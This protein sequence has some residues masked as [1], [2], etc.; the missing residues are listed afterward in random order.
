MR[1]VGYYFTGTG[2]TKRVLEKL[3]AEWEKRG[4]EMELVRIL[5]NT[6][7]ALDGYDRIIVGYPVHGFNAP[8]PIYKFLKAFPKCKKG[9]GKEVFLL[10]TSGEPLSL[11][12]ASGIVPARIL[13]RRGHSVVGEF[14][15]VMPYNIIFRHPDGMAAR[16]DRAS[17]L[18]I[19]KDC[20]DLEAGKGWRARVNPFKRAFTFLVRIEHPA[21]PVF[22]V[23]FHTKKKLCVGCGLC[24]KACPRGNITMKNGKPKFGGHCVGCMGCAFLCPKDAVRPSIFNAWRV[25]GKYNFDGEPVE[26]KKVIR[27]C[28]RHYLRYFH[29]AEALAALPEEEE[30]TIKEE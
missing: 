29:E 28:R 15:H 30:E 21:M 1:A 25:N 3:K 10:R 24:A 20:D 11:N 17:D 27:Y 16:M 14:A 13:K 6:L 5:P 26:D 9:E 18:K 4:H 8:T 12:H 19:V 2:N 7:P 23:S 22:G